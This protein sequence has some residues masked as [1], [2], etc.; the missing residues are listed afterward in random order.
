MHKA[1][2]NK[3]I[4]P[5]VTNGQSG[6][7]YRNKRLS[8]RRCLRFNCGSVYQKNDHFLL[9]KMLLNLPFSC[10]FERLMFLKK[11]ERN[12]DYVK[13]TKL[14]SAIF[15]LSFFLPFLY[16]KKEKDRIPFV[17]TESNKERSIWKEEW[18]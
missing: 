2:P 3:S 13:E 7:L 14:L 16:R 4:V 17:L 5:I 12:V 11:N 18:T 8:T 9:K 10:F 6:R 1:A 15:Y